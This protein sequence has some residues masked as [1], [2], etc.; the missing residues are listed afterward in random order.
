MGAGRRSNT[1][2]S[3]I[4][5]ALHDGGWLIIDFVYYMCGISNMSIYMY[6]ILLLQE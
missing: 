2:A 6:T 5:E 1:S 3:S 4:M